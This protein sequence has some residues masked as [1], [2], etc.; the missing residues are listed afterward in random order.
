VR[1]APYDPSPA[2]AARPS[3]ATLANPARFRAAAKFALRFLNQI[4][5]AD[6]VEGKKLFVLAGDQT[7]YLLQP[8]PSEHSAA[9]A[10]S[11]NSPK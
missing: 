1:I 4:A 6:F 8:V 9:N 10:P 5:M 11:S 3:L 2:C 7:G